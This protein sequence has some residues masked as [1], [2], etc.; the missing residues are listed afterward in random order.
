M[1]RHF[2]GFDISFLEGSFD[3]TQING[4]GGPLAPALSIPVEIAID[5]RSMR[6]DEGFEL[7]AISA[8]LRISQSQPLARAWFTLSRTIT[9]A[10]PSGTERAYF[11]FPLNAAQLEGLECLRAGGNLLLRLELT[12][13]LV[14]LHLLNPNRQPLD[15]WIWGHRQS[16]LLYL[17][18]DF[19]IPRETW[20]TRVLP[21]V[22]YGLV[23]VLEFPA[24]S[25]EASAALPAAF[26][27]LRQAQ[28]FHRRG[29][30]D[31]AA[32]KC[33]VALEPFFE[34]AEIPTG[35]GKTK[36]I[37]RLK[38]SWQTRLGQ[39]TYKWLADALDAV[40]YAGNPNHHSP[41]ARYGQLES[42]LLLAVT[43]AVV[44]YAVKAAPADPTP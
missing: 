43:A 22:G 16:H 4:I 39:P 26:A 19:E 28:E 23:H 7:K 25:L 27:A 8:K 36:K 5:H 3:V 41:H 35:E 15:S 17:Q 32:G 40:R 29:L 38:A 44:A 31:D 6:S 42:Q 10:H 18:E 33:R 34:P 11:E 20:L 21:N 13:E 30:Y 2:T 24:V 12:L 1:K 37:Q 14:H 9:S